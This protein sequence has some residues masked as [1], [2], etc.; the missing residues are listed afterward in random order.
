[1]KFFTISIAVL[2][3]SVILMVVFS[4]TSR[5]VPTRL[6]C[7]GDSITENSGYPAKLQEML[8]A[9]YFVKEF[10]VTGSTIMTDTCKPYIYTAAFFRVRE[11]LPNIVVIMLGTND[12]REDHYKSIENFVG[13]YEQ[14]VRKVQ[15]IESNPRILLVK[16]PPIFGNELDLSNVHLLE[17]VIPDIEQVAMD[18]DLSM[19]DVYTPLV[20]HPD[21][22]LDGVHPNNEGANIIAR[23]ICEAI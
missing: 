9:N 23:E 1:M 13:D 2:L 19:I 8:D 5:G 20:S 11:F 4:G 14:L 18:F 22:F 3:T 10:G 12:A 7:I 15:E 6:A 16:P 21:C 17:G